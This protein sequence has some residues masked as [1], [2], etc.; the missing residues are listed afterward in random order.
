MWDEQLFL[1]TVIF[2]FMKLNINLKL[3]VIAQTEVI[4]GVCLKTVE[5][6]LFI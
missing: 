4:R 6:I 2:P 5:C 3:P 1:A